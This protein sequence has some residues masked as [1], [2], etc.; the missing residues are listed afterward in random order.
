M[1]PP[2]PSRGTISEEKTNR[3]KPLEFAKRAKE[4]DPHNADN[5]AAALGLAAYRSGR[6]T[7][8]RLIS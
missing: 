1:C 2:A 3:I 8:G 7:H 4:Q 6:F 5:A